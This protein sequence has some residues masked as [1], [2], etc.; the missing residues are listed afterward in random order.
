MTFFIIGI[1]SV[2]NFSN[3]VNVFLNGILTFSK[4]I[5]FSAYMGSSCPLSGFSSCYTD[6]VP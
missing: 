4:K 1:I 2:L 5:Q 3:P 6:K